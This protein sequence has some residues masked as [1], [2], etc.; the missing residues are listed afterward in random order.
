MY[1]FGWKAT[2]P[3]RKITLSLSLEDAPNVRTEHITFNIVDMAYPY[4]AILG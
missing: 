1:D 4:N 3:I 2:L